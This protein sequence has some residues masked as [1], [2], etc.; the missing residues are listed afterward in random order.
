MRIEGS[1][2]SVRPKKRL[3]LGRVNGLMKRANNSANVN[4]LKERANGNANINV[5]I[6]ALMSTC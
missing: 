6:A 1:P 3:R 4:M 5:L 2:A